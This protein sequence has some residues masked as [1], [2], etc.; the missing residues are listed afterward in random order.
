MSKNGVIIYCD[1]ACLG[2]PGPGGYAALLVDEKSGQE[3]MVYG[4]EK[5]TTNNQMELLA[6]IMGLSALTKPCEVRVYS[7]SQYVVKGMREWIAGWQKRGFRTAQ[8]KPIAN[9]DLWKK[10]LELEKKHHISWHWVKGHSGH[11]QNERVDEIA[12]TQAMLVS[13]GI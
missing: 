8:N 10:L 11:E 2:N 1:G 7:D 4:Q 6:A 13:K 5:M 3:R 9:V 12:R